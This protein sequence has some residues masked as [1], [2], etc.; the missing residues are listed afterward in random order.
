MLQLWFKIFFRNQQKNWLNTLINILGITLGLVGII[1]V[2]LYFNS[3]KSYNAWNKHKNEVF[4]VAHLMSDG[5]IYSSS[6]NVEGAVFKNEI[7]EVIDVLLTSNYR[8]SITKVSG[9]SIYTEKILEADSNF[10]DFFPFEILEGNPAELKKSKQH[11]AISEQQAILLFKKG[12]AIGEKVEIGSISYIVTTVFKGN[13]KSYYNP[14]LIRQ[15]QN[16][17]SQNWGAFRNTLFCKI[18]SETSKKEVKAKMDAVYVKYYSEPYAKKQNTTVIKFEEQY[19]IK[20]ALEKLADIRLHPIASGSGPEGT[21]NFQLLAIMLVLSVLLL[22]ISAV[23][24]INLATASASQRAKEV[25]VKKTLGLSRKNVFTQFLFE[26]ITQCFVA[27]ILSFVIIELLLPYFNDFMELDLAFRDFGVIAQILGITILLSLI[28]GS[29]PALYTANFKTVEV[30]K[31]NISRSKKGII[32]RHFMLGLQF[33]ISGFFLIGVTVIFLQV[34]FMMRKD[35][36]FS[37]EKVISVT[38]NDWHNRVKKYSVAKNELIKHPNIDMV[39]TNDALPGSYGFSNTLLVYKDTKI[40]AY[41]NFIDFD[42]LGMMNVKVLKGRSFSADFASDTIKNILINKA[43]AKAFGIYDDPIGKKIQMGWGD[44]N[45][46][47][48]N[49]NIIG[50]I[51]NYHINSFEENIGPMFL[52]HLN[53]ISWMRSPRNI[54]IKIK[55]NNRLETIAFIENYWKENIEQGYPFNYQFVNKSFENTY[56]KYKKQQTMFA[57]LTIIVICIA[58]LGLFALATLNIQQRYKEVAIRKTLGAS[59]KEIMF[60]LLQNFLKIVIISSVILIPIA[61]YF[62]QNWLQNFVYRIDM[63]IIPYVLTPIILIVLVFS[64]VG[65]KAYKATKIDL[66]KYLKFE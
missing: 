25:G 7:P 42:Y 10:F 30:L 55:A 41:S 36:G 18:N 49:M 28:I 61:Y 32:L 17:L 40:T 23:N 11:I 65:F 59:V 8:S 45:N 31:G 46:D 48:K 33:L 63:P 60:Q 54:Q 9:K 53:T 66:I 27:L 62:M 1:I 52:I 56:S 43:A 21:G 20:V 38:L 50:V 44:K 19:G 51:D 15:F 12:N 39:S 24:V 37:G 22:I 16:E 34:Q 4:R 26:I 2:L 3:E 57:T 6:S 29:I 58:L 13:N 64:V 5:N 14:N 35:L 47:G